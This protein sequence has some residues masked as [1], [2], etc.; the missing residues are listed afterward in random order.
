MKIF[1]ANEPMALSFLMKAG[2]CICVA[3]LAHQKGLAAASDQMNIRAAIL[4]DHQA[5]LMRIRS[6]ELIVAMN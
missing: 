1:P 4:Q 6:L 3:N 2:M 5:D